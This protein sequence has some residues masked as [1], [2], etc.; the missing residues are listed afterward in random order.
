MGKGR[1]S[2]TGREEEEKRKKNETRKGG[3]AERSGRGGA[4]CLES[5]PMAGLA[6]VLPSGCFLFFL[7]C[8]SLA[9]LLSLTN[10]RLG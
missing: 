10:Y 8:V 9:V 3:A 7:L 5:C 6:L 1:G 2:L 4:G